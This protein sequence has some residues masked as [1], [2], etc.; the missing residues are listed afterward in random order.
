MR[1][2]TLA[3]LALVGWL[4]MALSVQA[5]AAATAGPSMDWLEQ[6]KSSGVGSNSA[7]A[8]AADSEGNV[9]AAGVWEG[10]VRVGPKFV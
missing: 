10:D 4:M 9:Y 6:I 1:S 2:I 7:N 3:I 8:V 5:A